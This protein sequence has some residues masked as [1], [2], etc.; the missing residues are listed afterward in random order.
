MRTGLCSSVRLAP[1]TRGED[2]GEGFDSSKGPAKTL[3]LPLSLTK[4]EAALRLHSNPL[5][6]A[7][8]NLRLPNRIRAF[9]LD[10]RDARRLPIGRTTAIRA[11]KALCLL[12]IDSCSPGARPSSD[13]DTQFPFAPGEQLQTHDS[14]TELNTARIA[15]KCPFSL[16]RCPFC[17]KVR[18]CCEACNS[19]DDL[20][21]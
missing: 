1:C 2:E 6:H 17:P 3:T 7:R 9:F 11:A 14:H 19:T 21:G 4:G 10:R 15:L 8:E 20:R 16:R 13:A 5:I 12:R 18:S